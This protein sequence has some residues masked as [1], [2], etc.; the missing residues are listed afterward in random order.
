MAVVPYR[1]RA[2][3]PG[4]SGSLPG[5]VFDRS[6]EAWSQA[7]GNVADILAN[8]AQAIKQARET[9]EI[10]GRSSRFAIG[11][12]ELLN[13]LNELKIGDRLA[14]PEEREQHFRTQLEGLK[15]QTLDWK[16]GSREAQTRLLGVIE[17][18]A[19]GSL[20]SFMRRQEA[21][22]IKNIADAAEGGLAVAVQSGSL[23]LATVYA[24]ELVAADVI[25]PAKRDEILRDFPVD[26]R[27]EQLRQ[28]ARRDPAATISTLEEMLT[29]QDLSDKQINRI[30]GTINIAREQM[31][32][33]VQ[34]QRAKDMETTVLTRQGKLTQEQLDALA[35]SGQITESNYTMNS[36]LIERRA[37]ELVGDEPKA[38]PEQRLR[39]YGVLAEEVSRYRQNRTDYNSVMA[40]YRVNQL[41]LS[42][43]D[44]EAFLDKIIDLRE[45]ESDRAEGDL[46]KLAENTLSPL[47]INR[48]ATQG[49]YDEL[50]L[51][52]A[53]AAVMQR[54]ARWRREAMGADKPFDAEAFR[55]KG[56]EI[57]LEV[58]REQDALRNPPKRGWFRGN[59]TAPSIVG[60]QP[61]QY[62]KTATNPATGER[63]GWDGAKWVPIR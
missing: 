34:V 62:E 41:E 1:R 56:N 31:G 24:N 33:L 11:T 39:A 59:S 51:A 22:E 7:T 63:L 35:L 12:Q 2:N 15:A 32:A 49:Q 42:E 14:T 57:I 36:A 38:T 26:A 29:Q 55:R 19:T 58:Y 37:K 6:M 40:V 48:D 27:I 47:F 13:G 28:G 53:V 52:D 30:Q 5:P 10:I 43:E 21:L 4:P 50:P 44:A 17:D 3:P 18:H 23:E 60:A 46:N 20:V 16:G 8:K 54:T 25:T 61:Q 45:T 9:T